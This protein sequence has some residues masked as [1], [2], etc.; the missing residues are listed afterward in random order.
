MRTIFI[1]LFPMS[2]GIAVTNDDLMDTL[3]YGETWSAEDFGFPVDSYGL[4]M[5]DDEL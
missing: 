4:L 1:A 3:R 2:F 5:V